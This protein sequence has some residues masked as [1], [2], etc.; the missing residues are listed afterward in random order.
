M[1]RLPS[2]SLDGRGLSVAVLAEQHDPRSRVDPEFGAREE[3]LARGRVSECDPAQL[4]Q[5]AGD[6]PPRLERE[7][8]L[9]VLLQRRSLVLELRLRERQQD[10][11]MTRPRHV[12]D[13]SSSSAY[14]RTRARRAGEEGR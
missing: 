14:A 7:R 6:L 8:Q 9:V 2:S 5:G 11:S 1:A 4:H 3:L 10:M 12:H 13:T